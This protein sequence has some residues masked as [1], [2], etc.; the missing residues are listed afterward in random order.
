MK[1][2]TLHFYLVF[3]FV[4][5]ISLFQVQA[6]DCHVKIGDLEFPVG[7][8]NGDDCQIG[9]VELEGKTLSP[10]KI[11]S[12]LAA[13]SV[14]LPG[15]SFPKDSLAPLNIRKPELEENYGVGIE[16]V[17]F[18]MEGNRIGEKIFRSLEDSPLEAPLL[19]SQLGRLC[20]NELAIGWEQVVQ[21]PGG[22]YAA[23]RWIHT[24][25]QLERELKQGW[26]FRHESTSAGQLFLITDEQMQART[27]EYADLIYQCEAL[28]S[29]SNHTDFEDRSIRNKSS[30][31][32]KALSGGAVACMG[33]P[34]P[35]QCMSMQQAQSGVV[36]AQLSCRHNGVET[37]DFISC[38]K[39][40]RTIDGFF[41]AKQANNT[42]Q[43]FRAVDKQ[44]EEQMKLQQKVA[45]GEGLNNKD[46]L[47]A[48]K[49]S[50]KHQSQ[51]AYERA[52]LDG[53]QLATIAAMYKAMP[54][55]DSLYEECKNARVVD[56]TLFS[57]GQIQ[58]LAPE[59]LDFTFDATHEKVCHKVL[60]EYA[61][62]ALLLNHEAKDAIKLA[63]AKAGFGALENAAKGKLLADQADLIKKAIDGIKEKEKPN[64]AHHFSQEELFSE[65]ITD[66]SKEGCIPPGTTGT[67]QMAGTN[68]SFNGVE[69][70]TANGLL[71]DGQEGDVQAA[72]EL[73]QRKILPNHLGKVVNQGS[74][75]NGFID[76]APGPG[77]LKKLGF[78]QGSGGGGGGLGGASLAT[79]SGGGS[80]G[81]SGKKSAAGR[82]VKV[83]LRGS[84]TGALKLGGGRFARSKKDKVA[85]PFNKFFNKKDRK[86]ASGV[87]KFK[88]QIGTKKDSLFTMISN[89]YD[90]VVKKERLLKYRLQD[91]KGKK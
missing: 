27:K 23:D 38:R 39:I 75:S 21:K 18:R 90:A 53:A 65:C 42:I 22:R 11:A 58:G 82:G 13:N 12:L 73:S 37:Q 36:G 33:D 80:R 17:A 88:K 31:S 4:T 5:L 86:P 15:P 63:M 55:R 78:H 3:T 69:G 2:K 35:Q 24:L 89:R 76:K 54:D 49:S 7:T 91:E 20:E 47:G 29:M 64:L 10:V 61:T 25:Q 45:D 32:T 59:G 57:Y 56:S 26:Y 44:T 43:E 70:N 41:I 81:N 77:S 34:N 46:V 71:G 8:A 66:P 74:G 48:Q 19:Y 84:G 9:P 6:N 40:L 62:Q 87:L 60:D 30:R 51:L 85:N 67:H 83:K 1:R 52:A 79:T 68:F 16:P 50:V 14:T 28:I 72:G